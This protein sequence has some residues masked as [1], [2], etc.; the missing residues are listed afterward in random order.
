MSIENKFKAI[1]DDLKKEFEATY[2]AAIDRVHSEVMPYIAED[3]EANAIYRAEDLARK[4]ITGDFD[5][6]EGCISV[7]G[8]KTKLTSNDYDKLVDKLAAKC[9][10]EAAQKKIARLERQLKEVYE[11]KS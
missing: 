10:D 8:W 7:N 5:L 11:V 1:S 9:S 3:T 4:I 2:S 6:V